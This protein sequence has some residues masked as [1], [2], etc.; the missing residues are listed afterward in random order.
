MTIKFG[1]GTTIS[2]FA[3]P[4]GGGGGGGGSMTAPSTAPV[5]PF[6]GSGPSWSFNGI[7]NGVSA[8]IDNNSMVVANG[9]PWCV[10]GF[11]YQTDNNA[12]PRLFS[13]GQYP[14]TSIAISL[15]GSTMYFWLNSGI[16][17]T[18]TKPTT[19]NWHHFAMASD[20]STTTFFVDGLQV[21][22]ASVTIPDVTGTTLWIGC[23][24]G[25]TGPSDFGG[26]MN[27]F[28]WTVGNQIYT[29]DFTVPTSALTWTGAADTNIN[30][31]TSGQVKL[32]Y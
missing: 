13:I 19:N 12:Y 26:Y 2:G 3:H 7:N 28:R 25:A 4:G 30:E 1:P 20:G 5:D 17:A 15:E 23:E 32:I 21:G 6:G 24:A 14:S 22:S 10:E 9:D 29:G 8:L 16:A 18:F 27:S 31:V 11:W